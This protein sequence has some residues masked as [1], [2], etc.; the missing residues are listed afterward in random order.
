MSAT[1]RLVVE[2]GGRGMAISDFDFHKQVLPP[3]SGELA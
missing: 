3:S 2:Q 1:Q